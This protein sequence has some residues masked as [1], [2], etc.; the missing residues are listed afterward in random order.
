[1]HSYQINHVL[2]TALMR[3]IIFGEIVRRLADRAPPGSEVSL[4][5]RP[6]PAA[7]VHHYHRPNLER[8]L[9]PRSL[10]T[11][12]HDLD[13]DEPW[14]RLSTFLP[15]YREATRVHCV[16]RTQ[17]VRLREQGIGHTVVIPHGVERAV[18]PVP[19]RRRWPR[20]GRLR[21]GIFSR[22]HEGGVKGEA[23]LD[24]L[25]DNLD[26]AR[27]SFLLVG[28]GRWREAESLRAKDFEARSY[29][30]VPYR[31]FGALY[32]GVDALLV[33][34][35][36]EGGPACVPE[37]LGAGIPVICTPVGLCPETVSEGVN[38]LFLT[39]RPQEDGARIMAL[40]EGSG[41]GL[42][43]LMEGA[44][45]GAAQVPSWDE[46]AAQYFELYRGILAEA[47]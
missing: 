4:T 31:L 45:A 17:Q 44:F 22:R 13:D 29:E 27:V 36:F 10:V 43:A 16:N 12:H 35:Q 5:T 32:A 34:S 15:R 1:M 47:A 8:R 46:V 9:A 23:F 6:D 19:G 18:F 33:V 25:A 38:G 37:A 30:R 20:D 26:P 42:A 14:L 40:L 21:L 2:S 41:A 11:V 39:R 24:A 3:S 28:E 7:R